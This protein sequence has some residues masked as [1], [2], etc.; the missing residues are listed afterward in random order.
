MSDARVTVV[1]TS[2]EL[3]LL[4]L[5]RTAQP[6]SDFEVN[7]RDGKIA[8]VRVTTIHRR[9]FEPRRMVERATPV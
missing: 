1:V 7:R 6:D 9:D 5:I 8:N 3:K 2:D 4:E